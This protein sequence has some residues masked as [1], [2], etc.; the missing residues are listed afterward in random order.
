M[1]FETYEKARKWEFWLLIGIFIF[2]GTIAFML[3]TRVNNVADYL[4]DKD[5]CNMDTDEYD[6]SDVKKNIRFIRNVGLIL[7]S[8]TIALAVI[9]FLLVVFGKHKIQNTQNPFKTKSSQTKSSQT[10]S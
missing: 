5:G 7:G 1:V 4:K 9:L 2:I 6:S 3:V 10:Q 8:I